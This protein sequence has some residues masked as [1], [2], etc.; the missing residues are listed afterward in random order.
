MQGWIKVHRQIRDSWIWTDDDPY[1]RRS[2]WID[3]LTAANHADAKVMFDGAPV[4]VPAGSFITSERKLADRWKWSRKK[5]SMFLNA[6]QAGECIVAKRSRRCTTITI[7]NWEKY[8]VDGATGAPLTNQSGASQE[9]VV[10]INK[11]DKNDKNVITPPIIPPAGGR[12]KKPNSERLALPEE[13]ALL[14]TL[15]ASGELRSALERW[16]MYKREKRQ[17]YTLTGLTTLI[18]T[19]QKK[20]DE[21]DCAAVIAVIDASMGSNYAGITWDRIQTRK[22]CQD[23]P[24]PPRRKLGP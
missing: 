6:L 24:T 18:K 3:L 12:T 23:G 16:L 17:T 20:A 2:A 10:H 19:A 15:G 9:P 4:V 8:Q 1:D 13:A 22:P 5:V 21:Y 11:N 14:N 7:V